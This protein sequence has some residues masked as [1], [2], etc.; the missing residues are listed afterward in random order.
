MK[1]SVVSCPQE[2][3]VSVSFIAMA[4]ILC[5]CQASEQLVLNF[6]LLITNDSHF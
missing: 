6:G 4:S 2:R 1:K 5:V 3:Y